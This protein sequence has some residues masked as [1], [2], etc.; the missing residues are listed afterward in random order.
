MIASPEYGPFLEKLD[1]ILSRPP[2]LFHFQPTPFPPH[3]LGSAPVTE[4]ATFF[5]IENTFL[6][7]VEKF[8][9]C[10]KGV[11]GYLGHVFG[12]TIEEI[13][14]EERSGNVGNA[15]L[16]CI[17]WESKE[18]HMRFRETEAFKNNIYLLREKTSGAE[19][20]RF[21]HYFRIWLAVD[22]G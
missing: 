3:V 15:V 20:V 12:E 2:K 13:E 18:A 4:M 7:N 1:T 8:I 17:G 19:M 6:A 14:K 21:R 11:D 5:Q 16:L 9:E 22:N 10:L